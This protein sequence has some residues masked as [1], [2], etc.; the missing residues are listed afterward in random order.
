MYNAL[1]RITELFHAGRGLD[2]Q[3]DNSSG[4]SERLRNGDETDNGLNFSGKGP[5]L[6]VTMGSY[7]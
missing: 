7:R 3:V 1:G 4:W 2:A 5:L 6:R